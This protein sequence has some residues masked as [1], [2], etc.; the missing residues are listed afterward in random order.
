V[1]SIG[2]LELLVHIWDLARTVGGDET[3]DAEAVV[4]TYE[5]LRPHYAALQAT[6]AFLPQVEPPA[7]ADP[8]TRFL[9]FTGRGGVSP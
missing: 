3:L 7:D 8:Q 4:R 9:C 6:G 5:I 2:A 1:D